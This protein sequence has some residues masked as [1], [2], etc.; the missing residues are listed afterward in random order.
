MLS[1]IAAVHIVLS[2]VLVVALAGVCYYGQRK[3]KQKESPQH[4]EKREKSIGL[5]EMRC[6]I[7]TDIHPC[8][9]IYL[10]CSQETDVCNCTS[11]AVEQVLVPHK[12]TSDSLVMHIAKP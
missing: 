2:I 3:T 4:S 9:H 12:T 7:L 5:L 8:S 10:G 11:V 1:F 6:F